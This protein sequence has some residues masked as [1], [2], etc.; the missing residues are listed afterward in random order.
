MA[1]AAF[2]H[3]RRFRTPI[4]IRDPRCRNS[5]LA[6]SASLAITI[7]RTRSRLDRIGFASNLICVRSSANGDIRHALDHVPI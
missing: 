3:A 4:V 5:L 7:Y 6:A 2:F 1:L